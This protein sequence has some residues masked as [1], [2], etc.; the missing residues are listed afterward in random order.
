MR[1]ST[2]GSCWFRLDAPPHAAWTARGAD[3]RSLSGCAVGAVLDC[4]PEFPFDLKGNLRDSDLR[5]AEDERRESPLHAACPEGYRRKMTRGGIALQLSLL[6]KFHAMMREM[7]LPYS[8][9][10]DTLLGAARHGGFVPWEEQGRAAVIVRQRDAAALRERCASGKDKPP[11]RLREHKTSLRLSLDVG[12]FDQ[13]HRYALDVFLAAESSPEAAQ[14]QPDELKLVPFHSKELWTPRDPLK[15]LELG[16]VS[17]E[18]HVKRDVLSVCHAA[19]AP[20]VPCARLVAL[21]G[22]SFTPAAAAAASALDSEYR[23]R[24]SAMVAGRSPRWQ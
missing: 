22:Y 8:L 3:A 10:R 5:G 14:L 4:S 19:K 6:D 1:D 12:D 20:P 9:F 2:N 13:R 23:A 15:L 21:C 7:Q 24:S 11:W 17:A 16:G 18:Q